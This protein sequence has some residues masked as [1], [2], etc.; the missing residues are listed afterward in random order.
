M[1]L[2]RTAAKLM[3][4]CACYLWVNELIRGDDGDAAFRLT[5]YI[6]EHLDGVLHIESICDALGISRRKLYAL[7]QSLYGMPPAAYIR[8]R[9]IAQATGL[10]RTGTSV[11]DTAA[12]V[13]ISDYNYFSKVYRRITGER[14]SRVK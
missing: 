9:R 8:T 4:A 3:E 10:L 11:A 13:G 7:S 6:D 5:R 1:F 12:A 2:V 14:P